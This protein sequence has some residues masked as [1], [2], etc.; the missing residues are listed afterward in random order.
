L[1]GV[2]A[3]FVKHVHLLWIGVGTDEP[4]TMKAGIECLHTSLTDAKVEH[5]WQTGTGPKRSSA[6]R[7]F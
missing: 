7:Q 1:A 2:V 6:P 4:P 5:E 3:A